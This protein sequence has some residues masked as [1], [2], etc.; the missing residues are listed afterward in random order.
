LLPQ[1]E[2][3]AIIDQLNINTAIES[4]SNT[5]ALR[6]LVSVYVCPSDF[7]RGDYSVPDRSLNPVAIA[8]TFSY[9][10]CSGGDESD[11]IFGATGNGAGL[12]VF[13]RNSWTST[14]D[15]TDGVSHTILIGERA[16]AN[17]MGIW[18]GALNNGT[19]RRGDWN[20]CPSTGK[21]F[22]PAA[23][24]GLAHCH[25]NNSFTDPDGALDDFSSM[26]PQG[27]NFVLADG[28]V[29][30]IRSIPSDL[31]SS[32]DG[33]TNYST[34]SLAFQ[35]MGTCSLRDSDQGLE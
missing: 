4:P 24:L 34:D 31:V 12:G 2:Q 26:H 20:K 28:S 25:L 17:A 7:L 19:L 32:P 33:S 27:S 8:T 13:F 22:Y 3:S 5:T 1:L 29:R 30:F 10:A 6:T 35:A 9:A 11:V 21:L 14:R 23:A 15:I 16:C 18:A